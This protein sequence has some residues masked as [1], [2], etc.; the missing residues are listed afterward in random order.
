MKGSK[1]N[2]TASVIKFPKQ[3]IGQGGGVLARRERRRRT[4]PLNI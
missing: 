2:M 4:Q 3:V 1:D